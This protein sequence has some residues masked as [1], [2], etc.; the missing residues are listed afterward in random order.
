MDDTNHFL[1]KQNLELH[2][3]LSSKN[4]NWA[5]EKALYEQKLEQFQTIINDYN[6][7]EKRMKDTHK[8]LIETM[9][10][11]ERNKMEGKKT[12]TLLTE[13]ASEMKYLRSCRD[14]T[15]QEGLTMTDKQKI[16]EEYKQM[17]SSRDNVRKDMDNIFSINIKNKDDNLIKSQYVERY[18]DVSD[19]DFN[20][21]VINNINRNRYLILDQNKYLILKFI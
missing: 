1:E 7:K 17:L 11:M 14:F 8:R 12:Q 13:L 2:K 4:Q 15:V 9:D 6:E 16:S 10:E 20:D 21:N 18:D 19:I 5:K 3:E